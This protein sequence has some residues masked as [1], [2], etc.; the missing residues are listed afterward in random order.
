[1]NFLETT[2]NYE[3]KFSQKGPITKQPPEGFFHPEDR[4]PEIEDNTL[5]PKATLFLT[6]GH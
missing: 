5:A 4:L 6:S 3:I 2:T 1:M